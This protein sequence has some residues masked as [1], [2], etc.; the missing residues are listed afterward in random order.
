MIDKLRG[1]GGEERTMD[2]EDRR[3]CPHGGGRQQIPCIRHTYSEVPNGRV[4]DHGQEAEF[5]AQESVL[6]NNEG[7][8]VVFP[9]STCLRHQGLRMPSYISEKSI[10]SQQF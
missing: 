8:R 2:R 10:N 4:N 9:A 3:G 6:V 1:D 7:F 5:G